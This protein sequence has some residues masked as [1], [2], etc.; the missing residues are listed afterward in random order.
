[1]AVFS[2]F[3]MV[4]F[5]YTGKNSQGM[6]RNPV[7]GRVDG[8]KIYNSDLVNAR[9]EW[10][11]LKKLPYRQNLSQANRLGPAADQIDRHPIMFVLLQKE[12][13]KMGVAVNNDQVQTEMVNTPGIETA[14][15]DRRAAI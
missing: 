5:A 9:N 7:I 13:Q 10:E 3:L 15:P 2:V 4:A 11:L 12:A 6:T 1:M 14:D 8:G